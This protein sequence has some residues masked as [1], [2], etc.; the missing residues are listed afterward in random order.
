MSPSPVR[1]GRPGHRVKDLSPAR[2][3]RRIEYGL[4]LAAAVLFTA[5]ALSDVLWLLGVGHGL[6][7]LTRSAA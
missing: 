4:F 2:D 3:L 1:T 5:G 7:M 6:P